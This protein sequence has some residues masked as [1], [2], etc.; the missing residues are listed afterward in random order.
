[1]SLSMA[2]TTKRLCSNCEHGYH[3]ENGVYCILF[4]HAVLTDKV[5][6]ECEAFEAI[7]HGLPQP[8]VTVNGVAVPSTVE[9]TSDVPFEVTSNEDLI[10]ACERFLEGRHIT[11]WGQPFEIISPSGRREAA[12]WL[13][14][15]VHDLSAARGEL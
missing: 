15:Q 5:A 9:H 1:M 11:L 14:Q 3:G 10:A 6:E 7:E 2:S 12:V 4:A 13:A 8:T